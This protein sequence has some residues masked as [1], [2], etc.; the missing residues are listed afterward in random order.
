M[1]KAVKQCG[2]S[3]YPNSPKTAHDFMINLLHEALEDDKSALT[4]IMKPLSG[5][6]VDV[7]YGAMNLDQPEKGLLML[8]FALSHMNKKSDRSIEQDLEVLEGFVR[9]MLE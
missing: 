9:A 7:K 4:M 2:E 6:M 3:V 5:G 1:A 8:A